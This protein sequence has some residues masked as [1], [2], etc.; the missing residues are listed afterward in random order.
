MNK[1]PISPAQAKGLQVLLGSV[2]AGAAQQ[3]RR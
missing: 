3:G 1:V 2:G